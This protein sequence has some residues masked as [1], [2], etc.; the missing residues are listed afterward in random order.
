MTLSLF[1]LSH[2]YILTLI[3]HNSRILH[4]PSLPSL[5]VSYT[6]NVMYL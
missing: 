6:R 1:S 2:F 5:S 3:F 4:F